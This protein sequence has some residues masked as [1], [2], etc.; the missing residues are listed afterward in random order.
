MDKD[1]LLMYTTEVGGGNGTYYCDQTHYAET[2]VRLDVGGDWYNGTVAGLWLWSGND[3]ASYLYSNLGGR[4][5]RKPLNGGT[6]EFS[7]AA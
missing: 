3:A 2:G 7:P 1:P 4:L 5:C 6:G